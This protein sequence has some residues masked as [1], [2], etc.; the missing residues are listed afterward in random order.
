MSI[1][2]ATQEAEI[3]RSKITLAKKFQVWWHM[4]V[5]PSTG[6]L[7]FKASPGKKHKTLSE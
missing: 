3:L 1:I 6:G 4:H 2:Q 7:R 5:I